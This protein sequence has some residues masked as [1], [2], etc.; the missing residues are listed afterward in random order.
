VL[1]LDQDFNGGELS[2]QAVDYLAQDSQ[3]NVWYVGSYTE[4]YEG[5]QF[6]N[7]S[8]AW[9]AGIDGAKAGVLMMADPQPGMPKYKQATIPD[10]GTDTAEVVD[11]GQDVCVPFKCYK[12]VLV[13]RE[14]G[15]ENKYFARGVGEIKLEPMSGNKQETEELVNLTQLTAS[16]LAELS[17]EAQ[18]LDEHARTEAPKVFGKSAVAARQP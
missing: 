14:G 6:V 18:R 13:V 3:G 15:S 2:E 12:D 5:G 7:A 4:A 8:D 17:A 10:Q 11:Q 1:V 9:L 16:G